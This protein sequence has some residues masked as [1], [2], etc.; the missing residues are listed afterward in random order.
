MKKYAVGIDIGGTNTRVALIDEEYHI[1]ERKQFLTF[2]DEPELTFQKIKEIVDEF[3]KQIIGVGVS[4][5]GPLDLINGQIKQTPN[6]GEKWHFLFIVE[7]LKKKLN[8]PVYLDNDANLAAL[9]EAIIG[10]GKE[11]QS[12]QFLTISTGLGAGLVMN[13]E[14]FIGAHGYAN[15]VAN[16][17]MIHNG[18]QH[19]SIY[20][21][22]IEAICSGTAITKRAQ[23][24]G[25]HVKHAG[26]VNELAK[27]GNEEAQIIMNDA[28]IYLA[29]F[30]AFIQA[31]IDPEIIILGGSVALKI[32]HFVEE[33]EVLVK[34]RVYDVVKPLVKVRKSTLDENSGLLGA[35]CLVF[36][37]EECK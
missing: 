35:A 7:A 1:I 23:N 3:D 11:Y 5:P 9:A 36:L 17:V 16:C 13:K 12:V 28:K 26:D 21:G 25:L 24:K 30:I 18:P 8:I 10:E 33:V 20:P 29:N 4:C 22:G 14:V 6:L 27:Q 31:Y 2:V 19:G 32:D 37:K 15:E 34:E